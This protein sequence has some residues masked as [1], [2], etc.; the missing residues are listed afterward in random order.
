MK[1]EGTRKSGV[2]KDVD[3]YTFTVGREEMRTLK[4][5]LSHYYQQIPKTIDT[6]QF[7]GRIRNMRKVLEN[8]K[9]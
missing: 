6:M 5:I 2:D 3:V 7:T 9:T 8:I 4:V 1:F